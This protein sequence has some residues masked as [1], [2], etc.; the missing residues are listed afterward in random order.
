MAHGESCSQPNV[1]IVIPVFNKVEFTRKC[2]EN[3]FAT[4]SSGGCEIIVVDNASSD[5]T[6]DFLATLGG[7]LRTIRNETNSGFAAACN[8]GARAATAPFLLFLNN[9]TEPLPG[10]LE[11][12]VETLEAD[13]AVG[14]V[15]SKLLFPDGT[16]QHAGV[17][18]I[19]DQL[20]P[21]PLV[22]R[23]I[24]YQQPGNIPDANIART[25]QALTAACILIR[26]EAFIACGGFDEGYW[27]G[28]EDVDLCF[29]LQKLG[30]QLVY[31]PLSVLIH[32]ESK[33]GQERFRLVTDNIKRLHDKWLDRIKPD[34]VITAG[35]ITATDAGFLKT[36]KRPDK[37]LEQNIS[38]TIP[39]TSIVI[40]T[41]NQ[42]DCTRECV[43][44]IRQFTPE[45]HE[46]IFV[47]NGSADGTVKWLRQLVRENANYRLIENLKNLGFAKGCNQGIEAASGEYILLLNNDVVVTENWLSGLLE[48]HRLGPDAGIVG[49][50]TNNISGPQQ[51][52][53]IGYQSLEGLA[54]YAQQFRAT[55]R[56]RIIPMRRIVG[57]CMLFP[58]ELVEK[59]GLLDEQFGTGNYEDDDY[60]LRT[61]LAGYRNIIA[62][63]V[64]IHHYG[65]RSFIGNRVD[66]GEAMTGNGKRFQEKWQNPAAAGFAELKLIAVRAV[67]KA[68]EC[69]GKGELQVAVATLLEGIKHAPEE[70]TLYYTL[71]EL[72]LEAKQFK[73]AMETV[74]Q[75]PG[76]VHD[77]RSAEL[78][79]Y[80]QKGLQM[81]V[82]AAASAD[83]ALLL[84][85]G[86]APALNLQGILAYKNG[87]KN[88]AEALFNR[89]IAADPSYGEPYTNAGV[90]NW[91][92][93]EQLRGMSLL[94]KGFILSPTAAEIATL[95]HTA[96]TGAGDVARTELLFREAAS[97]HPQHRGIQFFLIDLLLRQEKH[98]AAMELIEQAM[99]SYGNDDGLLGAALEVRSKIGHWQTASN[100]KSGST[101]SLC[102]IVKNEEQ[103]L[104]R[105]LGSAKPL[106]DEMVVVDTGSTDRTKQIAAAFGARVFDFPWTCDFAEAR[107]VSLAKA[108][109]DWVL[110][111]DADEVIAGRDH[112]ALRERVK[113]SSRRPAAYALV[114]RNYTNK[115][116][117][118]NWNA[119]DG[120]YRSEEAGSGWT[121]SIKV[122]LFPNDRRIRFENPVHELVE[123]SLKKI[124]MTVKAC[125]V[126]VHHYG[127][128]DEAMGAAKGE[129]YYQLGKQKIEALGNDIDA[130]CELAIQAGEL[131]KFAE[132][133][134]IWQRVVAISA[135]I[136]VAFFNMSAAYLELGQ[137]QEGLKASARAMALAPQMKEAIYNYAICAFYA[138][139]AKKSIA[140]LEDLLHRFPDNPS[141]EVMLALACC[142]DGQPGKGI[143]LFRKLRQ[144]NCGFSDAI[145]RVARKLIAAGRSEYTRLLLTAAM[146]SDNIN[147]DLLALVNDLLATPEIT[148][149]ELAQPGRG[150]AQAH[151]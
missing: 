146:E 150:A 7:L 69:Q 78:L 57:F 133:L 74:E 151:S 28:Y 83:R 140:I 70:T 127:K 56:H 112:E 58:R 30:W 65:S 98:A 104:A 55:N 21:D 66:Y 51:V 17:V 26:Q 131:K 97:L 95:Y 39:L 93:G 138:G 120:S 125:D 145:V 99:I 113:Q 91:G 72:L 9:D 110:I 13:P 135:D 130:L 1:S 147:P 18:V 128:L 32:H 47:D 16:I 87:D 121:P 50:M 52:L 126:P 68:H 54:E 134:E 129:A 76:N 117:I 45:P 118:E 109:A 111:L 36:Y 23:H 48:A 31:E 103:H 73:D 119:N 101:V 62:G 20:L 41:W 136:P 38:T 37:V 142:C 108:S 19:D 84:N 25:F 114:S 44:S 64:F 27:N 6:P 96:A 86:S 143:D 11:P 80:C 132:A 100:A 63:D 49:P 144:L 2:V 137:Y 115:V 53:Q 141:F 123:P 10:W 43:A 79:G 75:I 81:Y 94:E 35:G 14:A 77:A 3:L 46:I 24:Q 89:A 5:A 85:P 42:L 15:G 71:A 34:A 29:K 82:D 8:Q 105:C 60:C 149:N 12:L 40:L 22:A 92:A 106:V 67:E 139:D 122:R 90:I 124:C 59:I 88:A 61:A 33:S 107:N 148:R 116:N 4:T 102:M